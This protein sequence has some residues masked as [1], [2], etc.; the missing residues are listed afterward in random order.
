MKRGREADGS[1]LN[2]DFVCENQDGKHWSRQNAYNSNVIAQ[3]FAISAWLPWHT[4]P[5]IQ[6][7]KLLSL[8]TTTTTSGKTL[9]RSLAFPFLSSRFSPAYK[10]KWVAFG[11]QYLYCSRL[12]CKLMK[13]WSLL[14]NAVKAL[15]LPDVRVALKVAL[16]VKLH[17]GAG[18]SLLSVYKKYW[19]PF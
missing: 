4:F 14:R 9:S 19:M 7:Q 16:R 5:C 1:L 3:A 15:H 12:C 17:P 2:A 11:S 13:W 8:Q 18:S 10:N 6:I